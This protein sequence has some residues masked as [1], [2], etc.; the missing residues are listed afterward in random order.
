MTVHAIAGRPPVDDVGELYR[1]LSGR[2]EQIVGGGVSAP[3]A[4][5]EDAC[6]F[7]WSSL[8]RNR[9]R[10]RRDSTLAWLVTT[11]AREALHSLRRELHCESLEGSC[12]AVFAP[13]TVE[14]D[15]LVERRE[16]L[17]LIGTLSD[18]Q[19]RVLWL[20]AAGLSYAEIADSLGYTRRTVE[21]QLLR[22]KR[23]VRQAGA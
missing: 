2:L 21:R 12:D 14:P 11:A 9:D 10:V 1:R 18:R 13:T 16:R 17:A 15:E 3:D 20:H 6:Q 5:I 22:A 8:L 19:Q 23:S 7:A 4:V